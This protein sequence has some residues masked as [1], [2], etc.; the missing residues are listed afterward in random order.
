MSNTPDL[1]HARWVKS[2]YSGGEGGQC[3]EWAPG[4]ATASGTVPVRDS[5]V[6]DGRALI[7]SAHAW[8]AF[9]HFAR[10]QA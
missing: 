3:I 8:G 7:V 4:V 10:A 1:T 2:S 9:V 6:P 5:K